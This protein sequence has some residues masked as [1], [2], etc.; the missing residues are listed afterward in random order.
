MIVTVRSCLYGAVDSVF[1]FACSQDS[2][3]T[4]VL[5]FCIIMLKSVKKFMKFFKYLLNIG[6]KI[7]ARD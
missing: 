5:G 2:L 3:L 6:D 7:S 1:T 4:M